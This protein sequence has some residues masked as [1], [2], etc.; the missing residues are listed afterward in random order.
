MLKR[1]L[2]KFLLF[3]VIVATVTV[4]VQAKPILQSSSG[5][6]SIVGVG[7]IAIDL[8]TDSILY[9]KN[10][11]KQCTPASLTKMMTL[12]VAYEQTKGRH[13]ELI[14]VTSEMIDIPEG[15]SSA[16]LSV[17]DKISIR[18]LFSAMML[19]SGNDAAKT[20]AFVVS[21]GEKAFATLMNE[22]AQELGMENSHF[23]NAHG[24]DAKA[25]YTTTYDLALL[26]AELASNP[27]L[28]KIFSKVSYTATVYPKG[29]MNAE[30]KV[31]YYNTNLLL[32][33]GS[34]P[35]PGFKG[36]K[37]GYTSTAGN[38]LATF[39]ERDGRR[40]V[41]V[42]TNSLKG[43]RD[44]DTVAILKHCLTNFDTFNANEILPQKKIVVDIENADKEDESN[45]QLEIYIQKNDEDKFVTVTGDDGTKIRAFDDKTVSVRYPNIQAP[46][47]AGQYVGDVEFVYKNEVIYVAQAVAARN[48]DAE[49][50]TFEDLTSL[51]IKGKVR[52]SFGFLLSP[53]FLIPFCII[54][55]LAVLIMLAL[56][57]RKR[58]MLRVRARQKNLTGRRRKRGSRPGNRTML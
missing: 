29:D 54:I 19:P 42:V 35:Y 39:Y 38:C 9:A 15:S 32:R 20:L 57:L 11:N 7:G 26:A 13:D 34:S 40:I 6:P 46:V 5:Q 44:P 22:K 12:L 25:H 30:S 21:G 31:T 55:G 43:D 58:Q 3:A 23:V 24:F 56:F 50:P 51:G 41:I 36:I 4:S 27:E 16:N 45:G 48:V 37:T 18:D 49:I 17:G 1:F 33:E 28:V 53:Y 14:T 2:Y 10:I 52:I 8:D 47:I